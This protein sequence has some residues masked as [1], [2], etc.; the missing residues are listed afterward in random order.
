M[1]AEK[2]TLFFAGHARLPQGMA[3]QNIFESLSITVEID[4]RYSVILEASCTLVTDHGKA[5]IRNLLWGHSLRDGVDELILAI[6]Q[7][8]HG[9]ASNALIAAVK[10]L[11]QQYEKSVHPGASSNS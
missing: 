10:D 3:A 4:A 6:Q 5:F 7:R 9:R 2:K 11:Y 8:Y 1:E